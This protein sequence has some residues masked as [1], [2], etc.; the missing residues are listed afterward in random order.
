MASGQAGL[1]IIAVKKIV[2][3]GVACPASIIEKKKGGGQT[4]KNFCLTKPDSALLSGE[5]LNSC[6]HCEQFL[7]NYT[8]AGDFSLPSFLLSLP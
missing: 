8:A 3:N 1:R 4:G 5:E 7:G 2:S 6:S